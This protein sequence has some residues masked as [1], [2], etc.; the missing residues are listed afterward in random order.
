M[1]NLHRVVVSWTGNQVKGTAVSVLHFDASASTAPPVAALNTALGGLAGAL[2][3]GVTL[4]VPGSGD[5]IDAS[6][7]Q[8]VSAWTATAPSAIT[9]SGSAQCAAGVGACIT[10]STALVANGRRVRGR[11]F[12]VPLMYNMYDVDG[13]FTGSGLTSLQNAANAIAG[14]A[15]LVV[16]HRPKPGTGAT[17]GFGAVTSARVRD[18]VA[19]L[20]SRRD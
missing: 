8:L 19:V 7:G 11:M 13:T 1:A 4:Q 20:A 6:S 3:L 14:V 2:P 12:V 9:G 18:H 5:T 17:G 10:F 16:W 15:G